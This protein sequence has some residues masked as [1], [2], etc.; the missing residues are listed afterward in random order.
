LVGTGTTPMCRL[1]HIAQ[2]L[3]TKTPRGNTRLTKFTLATEVI[4][5]KGVT[6]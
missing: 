6:H 3:P 1:Y 5:R 2:I 4:I